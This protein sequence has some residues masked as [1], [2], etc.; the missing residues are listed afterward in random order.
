MSVTYKIAH[1]EKDNEI[2]KIY[3]FNSNILSSSELNKLF[4]TNSEDDV[5]N[6]IFS[7]EELTLIK[8]KNIDVEFTDYSIYLDD[9]IETIKKKL[10]LVLNNSV[11]FEEI[12]LFAQ[13]QEQLEVYQYIK[14]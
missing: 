11:S 6:E 14:I 5:F 4:K 12:Y 13:Q 8:S 3:V 9:T 1:T 10:M 7:K 2:S